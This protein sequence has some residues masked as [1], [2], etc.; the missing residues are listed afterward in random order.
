M[1]A[2]VKVYSRISQEL[3]AKLYNCADFFILGSPVETYCLAAVEACLCNVPVIMHNVGVFN[4][5][6]PTER[7]AVGIFD[8]NFIQAISAIQQAQFSPRET[9]LAKKRTINDTMLKWQMLLAQIAAE[10]EQ[11]G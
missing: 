7:T 8:M 4:D 5:F 11:K 1:A 3:L 10:F 2:N 9:V 6:T